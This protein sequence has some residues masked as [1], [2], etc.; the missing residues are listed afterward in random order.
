MKS[1]RLSLYRDKVTKKAKSNSTNK[2]TTK[3]SD[4]KSGKAKFQE[5]AQKPIKVAE[6]IKQD[7]QNRQGSISG[8][9]GT[10]E[11]KNNSMTFKEAFAK[12]RK[13]KGKDSTFTWQ[14]KSYSTVTADDVKKAGFSSLKEYLN[15]KK[16]K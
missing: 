11:K 3:K 4:S 13:E 2:K 10:Y 6:K 14:G 9:A 7:A 5:D 15:S 12:A 16:K 8:N 1:G